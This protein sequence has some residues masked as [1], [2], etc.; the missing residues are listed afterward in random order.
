MRIG[1]FGTPHIAA[2]NLR[3]L[4]E[5]GHDILFAVTPE[6][7]P[8][9]RGRSTRP[10][11]AKEAARDLGIQV[12]HP[13]D[14]KDPEFQATLAGSGAEACVVV[15]Y[16][17]IIPPSIFNLPPLGT[18]NLHPSLLPAY[19]GAAPIPWV[20]INGEKVTGVTVQKINERMDAGDIVAREKIPLDDK[21]TAGE[22]YEKVLPLGGELLD[23]SL[24]RIRDP[25]F[26]PEPQD[27]SRATYCGKLSTDLA[28]IDWTRPARDIHN[29]VRGCNPAPGAWTLFRGQTLK[30]WKTGPCAG[31]R[32]GTEP[33]TLYPEEKGRLVAATGDD[34]LEI[35]ELQQQGKRR[36]EVPAF[37]NGA[38]LAEGEML[39]E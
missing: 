13:A 17:K 29:L 16:G 18:L 4:H 28:K 27:E 24:E 31:G 15:A 33:G 11:A 19:R 3:Y 10:C 6:D 37:I 12:F 25:G 2:W 34:D 7:R 32:S 30:I 21:I 38:R 5:K 8:A 20:L 39:G 35:I 22:L 14:L 1:F 26:T 9:G 23:L 36:M